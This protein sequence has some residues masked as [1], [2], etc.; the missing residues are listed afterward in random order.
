MSERQQKPVPKHMDAEQIAAVL[1]GWLD[2]AEPDEYDPCDPTSFMLRFLWDGGQLGGYIVLPMRRDMFTLALY[3]PRKPRGARPFASV[4][5]TPQILVDS[6]FDLIKHL[7]R[8][9]ANALVAE[10][11]APNVAPALS[12]TTEGGGQ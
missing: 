3:D 7:L 2:G 1:K 8:D 12:S 6:Q 9:R 11:A 10:A 5:F 4:K